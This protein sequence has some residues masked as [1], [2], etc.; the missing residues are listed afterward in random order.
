MGINQ[1]MTFFV[2]LGIKTIRLYRMGIGFGPSPS[3]ADHP[4]MPPPTSPVVS[5]V[6]RRPGRSKT[7]GPIS[8]VCLFVRFVHYALILVHSFVG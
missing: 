8:F 2:Y 1:S 4:A 5:V 7:V 6:F 3:V